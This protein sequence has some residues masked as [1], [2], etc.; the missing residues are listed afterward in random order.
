MAKPR[1]PREKGDN[2]EH[3]E[4]LKDTLKDL[5]RE[6]LKARFDGAAY[7][8]LARAHGYADGYMRAMLDSG[9]MGQKELLKLVGEER[10]RFIDEVPAS[11]TA[12]A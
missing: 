4:Q 7:A 5:L 8:K 1:T 12:A 6:V 11:S 10:R 9:L 2:M 3:R